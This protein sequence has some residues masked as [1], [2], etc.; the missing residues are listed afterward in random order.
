MLLD[1]GLQD[2]KRIHWKSM[3]GLGGLIPELVLGLAHHCAAGSNPTSK[4]SF[5]G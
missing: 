2:F 3:V 5:L 4:G 1:I